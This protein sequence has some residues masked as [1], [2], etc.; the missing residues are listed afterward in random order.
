MVADLVF[1]LIGGHFGHPSFPST[2]VVSWT[3]QPSPEHVEFHALQAWGD[4]RIDLAAPRSN[5]P[6]SENNLTLSFQVVKLMLE[7]SMAH[8]LMY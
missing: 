2:A 4:L 1:A 8:A 3:N 5:G 6:S 7:F